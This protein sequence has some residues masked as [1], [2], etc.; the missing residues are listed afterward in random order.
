[1]TETQE[2]ISKMDTKTRKQ[3]KKNFCSECGCATERHAGAKVKN[4]I[5]TVIKGFW[6]EDTLC[7][8]TKSCK[9]KQEFFIFG[10]D[11]KP[12]LSRVSY[13]SCKKHLTLGITRVLSGERT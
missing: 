13:S 6:T 5:V 1:M 12:R 9:K 4:P 11:G 8:V 7:S 10:N 3:V 2:T